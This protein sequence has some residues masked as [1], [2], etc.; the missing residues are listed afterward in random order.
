[1]LAKYKKPHG[2]YSDSEVCRT[3]F[4]DVLG[5]AKLIEAVRRKRKVSPQSDNHYHNAQIVR[6]ALDL[7]FA[8]GDL[9]AVAFE[10]A[11]CSS[12]KFATPQQF[13]MDVKTCASEGAAPPSTFQNVVLQG[14]LHLLTL[15]DT[16]RSL[17]L[18][19]SERSAFLARHLARTPNDAG[20]FLEVI[21]QGEHL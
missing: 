18:E 3:L 5:T 20:I 19:M 13:L 10:N 14:F 8:N 2:V 11:L 7:P 1:M 21:N 17:V 12:K 4:G 9:N 15:N 16:D 6:D